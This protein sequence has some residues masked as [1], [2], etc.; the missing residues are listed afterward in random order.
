[1]KAL[2]R[3]HCAAR[4]ASRVAILPGIAAILLAVGCLAWAGQG[5]PGKQAPRATKASLGPDKIDPQDSAACMDCHSDI[6]GRFPAV[7]Q[8]ALADSPHK[9][10]KCQD[11]HASIDAAPHTAAMLSDKA[12]CGN[13]H[14]DESNAYRLSSHS[15]AD[16][17]AGDH[18]TCVTCHAD[19][20]PHGVRHIKSMTRAEYALMCSEC[21][22]QADRMN[23]YG[24]DPDAA[25]SYNESFHGR[26]VLKFG[27]L[28]AAIC[29]DC[30]GVHDVLPPNNPKARTNRA[31][32]NTLCSKPACHPGA[33]ANFAMSGANH[34][35]L[36]V[37]RGAVLHAVDLFFRILVA[38]M[39][40]FLTG[41]V[42]L[43]LRKKVF[44]KTPPRSGRST[45]LLTSVSFL[46]VCAA[47]VLGAVNQV[48]SSAYCF[49]ASVG[50][51][52]LA[53]LVF[54]ATKRSR[55][56]SQTSGETFQ[57]FDAVHRW[58]H[59]ALMV[60]FT[61][62]IA[63][64]LPLRFAQVDLL[65]RHYA[66]IGGLEGARIA[67]RIAAVAMILVGIW[68]VLDLLVRWKRQ[69]FKLRSLTMLPNFKDVRD[70]IATTLSYVGLS[71]KEPRNDRFQFRQKMDYLAEY[72]GVPI[73]V[74]TG[75]VLWFPTYWGDRLPEQA[76]AIALVAHG[77]EATLAF[78]AIIVWH[79]Y[80]EHFNP[81]SFPMSKVW[82]TGTMSREEM[83]R[84]HPLELDRLDQK[85]H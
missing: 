69:G 56:M 74:L 5:A 76:V 21:H 75:F 68:H 30:H 54:L 79:L 26:A 25:T 59:L 77:W 49:A 43:D 1:M 85:E 2:A 42:A 78:C 39:V 12:S 61:A 18:P 7:K 66:Y 10:L 47:L 40:L 15:H 71:R 58:Q 44:A 11:C 55:P 17:V 29:S 3:L 19:G 52:L 70:F 53:Y 41:G 20:D 36:M 64:G 51:L 4:C 23:R 37:K 65:H 34:L 27:N 28:K 50:V 6:Q 83:E 14:E 67:H 46:G 57:R 63:T 33:N 81:D 48:L 73:M 38:G 13:C 84:E 62:L 8:S 80:N 45:A 31:N 35:R 16:K 60:C 32:A 24:A 82:L 22:A 9:D 72:W